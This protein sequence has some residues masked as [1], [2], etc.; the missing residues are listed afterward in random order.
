MI[1]TITDAAKVFMRRLAPRK[2]VRSSY[3]AASTNRSNQRHW[4]NADGLSAQESTRPD[5]REVLRNRARY[6]AHESGGYI[7]GT[8]RSLAILT[9]GTGPRLQLNIPGRSN[10]AR[11]IE[12]LFRQWTYSVRLSER[13][14]TARMAK[15][16]DGEVFVVLGVNPSLRSPV[17]L[18][19]T[20]IEAD[21]VR[22]GW[23]Q[24][25]SDTD[26]LDDGIEYDRFGNPLYYTVFD[27]ASSVG[28]SG[29][30][31]KV[32][33]ASDVLH[34]YREDR[35]GQRRGVPEFAA[36]LDMIPKMQRFQN[37]TVLAAE[38]AANH[39]GVLYT[40]DPD[41]DDSDPDM[42]PGDVVDAEANS[43]LVLSNGRKLA[44]L[45]A[46]H[47][48]TTFPMFVSELIKDI[49]RPLC[50]TK[51][52]ATGDSSDSNYAS[53][54]LDIQLTNQAI[55]IE[56]DYLI[57]SFLDPVFERW[58]E[59][60]GMIGGE[61]LPA[62]LPDIS[63]WDWTWY[64]DA[65]G[66]V[67]PVKEANAISTELGA[68]VTTRHR[69]HQKRGLDMEE[70]DRRAA[71][72]YGISVAEYRQALFAKTFA[73]PQSVAPQDQEGEKVEDE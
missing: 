15:C 63:E 29:R 34:L 54:R 5:V 62:E 59:F 22:Q 43:L 8:V 46:E 3:D 56:R 73:Q 18:D 17:K 68:G 33:H 50:F 30:D 4:A 35:P 45:K 57:S 65:M 2:A 36:S 44:Q 53:A 1:R 60:A 38:T 21:R 55:A 61:Y 28:F 42:F 32:F 67:D 49:V 6:V 14:R 25:M 7:N 69:E 52:V 48:A 19:V 12:A 37:A 16:V 47:P 9:V 10:A 27:S 51:N 31:Y 58:V 11:E 70:E 41:P 39:A 40:D 72:S 66:H 24:R 23:G 71:E 64:W 20:L 26:W 13:L